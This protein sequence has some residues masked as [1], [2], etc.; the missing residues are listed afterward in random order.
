MKGNTQDQLNLAP[1][2]ERAIVDEIRN[3]RELISRLSITPQEIE[4]LSKCALLGTLTCKQDMLFILRQIREATSPTIDHAALFP[5]PPEATEA[6]EEPGPD[7]RHLTARVAPMIIPEPGSLDSIVRR[8]LP[9][10]FGVFFWVLVLVV[11]LAWNAVIFMSRWRDN[12]T[13]SFGAAVSQAS[14]ADV[15]YSKLDHLNILLFWEVLFVGA[16]AF[17]LH[18]KSQR[19]SRRFKIRRGQRQR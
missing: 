8:R 11:G 5:K 19:D 2:E 12:F 6:E 4:A 3:D 1:R 13:T 15:W 16:I 17:L 14:A 10:Q 7:L 9:E 18:L